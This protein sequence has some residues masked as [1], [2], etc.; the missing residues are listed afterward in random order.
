M[1]ILLRHFRENLG[2]PSI[3]LPF[4]PRPGQCAMH[5]PSIT[6][7]A[8]PM[9]N[10]LPSITCHCAGVCSTARPLASLSAMGCPCVGLVETCGVEVET[11]RVEVETGVVLETG[12]PG[13][14]HD[15]RLRVS[16]LRHQIPG[17]TL[18]AQRCPAGR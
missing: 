12:R 17:S 14:H 15:S 10:H 5:L 16:S 7:L 2:A 9:R 1:R 6:V 3:N 18:R 11:C 4:A 8:R 13:R